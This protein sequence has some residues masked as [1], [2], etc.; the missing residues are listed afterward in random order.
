MFL[1]AQLLCTGYEFAKLIKSSQWDHYVYGLCLDNGAVFYVG[2]GVGDRALDHAKEAAKGDDSEK[3]RYIRE[4]GEK[5]RYTIFLQC[6]DGDFALG[7]E[8]Y[9][10]H[11]HH[12]V[13]TNIASASDIAFQRM[14]QPVDP[15]RRDLD[16]L[17]Y[18]DRY[19]KNANAECRASMRSIIDGCPAIEQTLT[20][21]ELE[22]MNEECAQ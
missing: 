4:I 20:K 7:Y 14:F 10:I 5:I 15:I 11:G 9:L 2:K 6:S 19:V 16:S 17:A 21:E 1:A 18:V 3:S 8:A 22:W 12:D 13:L